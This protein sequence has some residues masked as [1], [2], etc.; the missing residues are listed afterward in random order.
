MCFNI[1]DSS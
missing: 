1:E